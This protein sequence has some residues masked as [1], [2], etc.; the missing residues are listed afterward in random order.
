MQIVAGLEIHIQLKTKTKAFSPSPV[1]F[2]KKPNSCASEIDMGFP[3]TLPVVN[4]EML[5]QAIMLGNW[6]NS[7][8][9]SLIT[10]ARKHYFYPDLPKGYQITQDEC[11]ILV[12]GY[13]DFEVNG[14]SKRCMLDHAHL[15]ED[16]GKSVHGYKPGISGV[17]LNRAGQPLLEI[18]TDPTLHSI[19]EVVAFL[20]RLHSIV[21]YLGICD[22]NMQ[23]GSFRADVNVSLRENEE[24]PF[25]TRVELKN[26]NSFKF[27]QKALEYEVERQM[28][29][30]EAGKPV[31]Q[32]TRLY[33]EAKNKTESM[34]GKETAHD[35]RY[36][37]DP[38]L[39]PIWISAEFIE[40]A[41]SRL[42]VSPFE[43]RSHYVKRGLSKV[44]AD[45]IA[46]NRYMGDYFEALAEDHDPKVVANWLL[47]P[48]SALANKHQCEFSELPLTTEAISEVLDALSKNTISSK[49]AKEIVVFMWEEGKSLAQ[50]MDEKG[51][52]QMS[53]ESEIK[54]ILNKIL[55]DN[56]KQLEEYRSGKDKLFGFF[57]GQAMKATKGQANPGLLNKLLKEVLS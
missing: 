53:N 22:G 18:V 49:M 40:D 56:P 17:D 36:F 45:I 6:L 48:I 54:A 13:L 37:R 29:L 11:P 5:K 1:D 35:Y 38:D 4:K 15:E 57:V 52:K 16:A 39:P 9:A 24:A 33:N 25:G 42:P 27:I 41:C 12:G 28:S 10:F 30:I 14:E 55:E 47:G 23:E 50:V 26:M 21:T 3:G 8:I 44:D 20:K 51:L 31:I 43:R 7:D 32:E 2:G 34:R 19:E 46:F